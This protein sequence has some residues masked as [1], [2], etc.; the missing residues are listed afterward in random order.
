MPLL[1]TLHVK[2]GE[3]RHTLTDVDDHCTV[4][5][6]KT[7][8]EPLCAV[9]SAQQRLIYKGR[10]LADAKLLADYGPSRVLPLWVL[11]CGHAT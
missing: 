5:A 7:R 9:D 3:Q 11:C 6:L 1:P 8:L 2:L 4:G 10:V